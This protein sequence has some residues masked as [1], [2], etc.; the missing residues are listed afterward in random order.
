MAFITKNNAGYA[1]RSR[2]WA[3]QKG[4]TANVATP[5]LVAEDIHKRF[6]SVE[7]T[8]GVMRGRNEQGN[9]WGCSMKDSIEVFK[10]ITANR[11][12]DGIVVYLTK[13]GKDLGWSTSIEEAA[14]FHDSVVDRVLRLAE[15][16][17]EA[18]VVVGL[19]AIEIRG[20]HRPLGKRETI[21]ASGGPSISYGEDAL[22]ADE[23][24]YVI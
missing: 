5:A 22:A 6:G 3:N 16:E 9:G 2:R 19:Y 7:A 10:V 4:R 20:K 21:R 8:K 15:G 1:F 24:D 23:P 11:L 13:A 17:V 18:N 14:I 12:S